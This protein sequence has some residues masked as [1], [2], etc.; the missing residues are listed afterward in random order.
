MTGGVC[1]N[2]LMISA[3][4]RPGSLASRNYCSKLAVWQNAGSRFNYSASSRGSSAIT[5]DPSG[6][7]PSPDIRPLSAKA[8]IK[9]PRPPADDVNQTSP[10]QLGSEGMLVN[11][12]RPWK[13]KVAIFC[14]CLHWQDE[15]AVWNKVFNIC[16]QGDMWSLCLLF[17]CVQ[18]A[19][20]VYIILNDLYQ[21]MP[22]KCVLYKGYTELWQEL[23][24]ACAH[25][26]TRWPK[27]HWALPEAPT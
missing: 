2:I 14:P 7:T 11:S 20:T 22:L 5:L 4:A 8:Y 18:K 23:L 19:F 13:N 24:C 1:W 25:I 6:H 10:S 9:D 12:R 15:A 17:L 16:V 21:W 3:V 26:Y 27:A